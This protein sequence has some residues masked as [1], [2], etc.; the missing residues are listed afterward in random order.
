MGGEVCFTGRETEAREGSRSAAK[1]HRFKALKWPP[2][3]SQE[4]LSLPGE[5][6]I[7][8]E[9][10]PLQAGEV[11]YLKILYKL[12]AYFTSAEALLFVDPHCINNTRKH[13]WRHS[14]PVSW[15]PTAHE[16]QTH[17]LHCCLFHQHPEEVFR[18][19]L[20]C[21]GLRISAIRTSL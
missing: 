7:Q 14:H 12:F 13:L 5:Y 19:L 4:S 21:K 18:P 15:A 1:L 20:P 6:H 3:Y 16:H 8:S 2:S 9:H 11:R 17:T 10:T